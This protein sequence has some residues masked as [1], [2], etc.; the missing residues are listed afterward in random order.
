[1]TQK[2]QF[3]IDRGGTFTDII[4]RDPTGRITT[5]KLLSDN[6]NHY[7][8][9]AIHGIHCLMGIPTTDSLP[10]QHIEAVRMGTTVATNALLEHKGEPLL[11]VTT[12]GFADA[13]RIGYQQRPDLFALDI[14]LPTMLYRDVIEIDE[15]LQANGKVLSPIDKNAVHKALKAAWQQGLHAVAIVFMHGYRYPQHEQIVAEIAKNIGFSQ[16]S[17]SHQSNPVIRFVSRGDTTV[18]DAYLSPILQ[19]YTQQISRQLPNTPL[20]FMQSN[21]GLTE[22]SC[23]QGKDAILSGPAGGIVGMVRTAEAEGF[24]QVIGFDMGGT[25]TDVCHYNGEYETTTEAQIAGMRVCAPML[26]IHTIAAGGGSLL[27]FDQERFSVGPDSAGSTP[28]PAAYGAGGELTITD[29][30]I[31]LGK[32]QP[33]YFPAIF[34]EQA[35]SSLD[36]AI[37]QRKFS[38]FTKQST[39]TTHSAETIATGFLAIA[40]ENMANSIKKISVQRGYDVTQYTLAC[41]GGAGGQ[42]ACLVADALGINR[43]F[44][45]QYSGI[46]S[47]YGMG[48]ADHK[49]SRT[50]SIDLPLTTTSMPALVR[51][52]QTLNQYVQDELQQQGLQYIDEQYCTLL[53]RYQDADSTLKI[54]LNNQSTIETLQNDFTT[55]H[56]QHYGFH[57]PEKTIVIASMQ[58]DG[59]VKNTYNKTLQAQQTANTASNITTITPPPPNS[60]EAVYSQGQWRTVPFYLRDTL[61]Q[62]TVIQGPAVIVETTATFVIEPTWQ[63]RVTAQNNIVLTRDQKQTEQTLKTQQY[64][65][66]PAAKA[67]PAL[68]EIFNNLFMSIAEQMGSVLEKTAV[69]VNIKERMD[70]SC[71]VFDQ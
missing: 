39:H 14:E 16:I 25:S 3:W 6:P 13:L 5:H 18:V 63:A 64:A 35:D 33:H 48:L 49:K 50:Q 65:I 7:Q 68:L 15:R 26:H 58:V 44:F 32:L 12:K 55:L 52:Q 21:G 53:C 59:L 11:L 60:H 8:D 54:S 17:T 42:H 71:A 40:V 47:A 9:A 36:T 45:H 41:F 31:L 29:C 43:I 38:Q 70:F 46:L 4:A 10:T 2:W 24:K 27:H 22:A 37:V 1:M 56:Q 20:L 19:R 62:N 28:G 51:A 67:D 30:N 66:N 69:S 57:S 34:G 23:F 61:Q